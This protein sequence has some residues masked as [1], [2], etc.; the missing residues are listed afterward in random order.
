[1]PYVVVKDE[2]A[3]SASK[4]WAVKNKATGDLRG[5]HE[6]KSKA[7]DQQKALYANVP[8]ARKHSEMRNV[9]IPV[10]QFSET[11]EADQLVWLQAYPYKTWSHPIFSDTTVDLDVAQQMVKNF[12]EGVYGQEIP[13]DYEHGL[14]P[15]KGKKASGWV[16][17]IEARDDGLYYGV[18]FTETA[19]KEIEAGEWKYFSAEHYDTWTDPTTNESF[20]YVVA[21]GGLTNKPWVKG[22]IPLNFS[23]VVVQEAEVADDVEGKEEVTVTDESKEME[24]SEPG[25]GS[26][27][28]P[29][30]DEDGSD[31]KAIKEGW[32]RDQPPIVKE[33]E[34]G[35][36]NEL[37]AKLREML[38]LGDDA[39]IIKAVEQMKGEVTPL[40]EAAKAHS[41]R[42]AFSEAYPDEF[43]RLQKLEAKDRENEA[44][45]FSEKF[46][47][48][49][50]GKGF[51]TLVQ[52]KLQGLH[53]QFSEGSATTDDLAELMELIGSDKGVVDYTETGSA[54]A[55]KA[56]EGSAAKVFSERVVEIQESDKL[57]YGDAVA[58]AARRYPDEF[59]AY[60]LNP[61]VVGSGE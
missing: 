13:T 37:D 44:K 5:C 4:P 36:E 8:D 40:R 32:R 49:G 16:K 58:E 1:M 22:M 24:H 59:D 7:I 52:D 34:G 45:A 50:E 47:S 17:A 28:A 38:D 55:K 61:T 31:D 26:P 12:H 33:L 27:P 3:C 21:G 56:P 23:E 2:K 25:S 19:R 20:T 41:E 14:D 35:V 10:K 46:A 9:L 42:K 60:R 15:A 43:K 51:S 54:R 57:E 18:Q 39:D 6:S 53:K 11:L 30:T 48:I 29:R